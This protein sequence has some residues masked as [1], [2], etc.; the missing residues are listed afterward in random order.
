MQRT[1]VSYAVGISLIILLKSLDSTCHYVFYTSLESVG[2][3]TEGKVSIRERGCC[4]GVIT[5]RQ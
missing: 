1:N 5:V 2:K 3:S 4:A